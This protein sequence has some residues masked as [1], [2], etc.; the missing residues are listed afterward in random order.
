MVL[1]LAGCSAA[2]P[3][4]TP[5]SDSPDSVPPGAAGDPAAAPLD[6]G[7][8]SGATLDPAVYHQRADAAIETMLLRYWS[9]SAS[10]LTGASPSAGAVSGYWPFAQ[11]FD[12]VIDAVDRT[13]GARFGGWIEGLYLAENARGWS[14]DYYDD[15]N[16]MTLALMRA[17]DRNHSA[18]YLDQAKSLFADIEAGWDTTCC[19]ANPGG[20]WWNKTHTQKATASNA[21]PVIAGVRLAARTGDAAALAFAE[22]VYAYWR[23]NMVD[24][25]TFAVFDHFDPSGTI[26]K[27]RFTYNEGLMIGAAVELYGATKNSSYLDDAHHIAAHMLAA[28]TTTTAYGKVLFDGTNTSCNNDCQQF[29]GIGF[30]YLSEL[31]SIDESHPEYGAVLQAS[32]EAAWHLARAPWGQFATDWAGPAPTATTVVSLDAQSSAAMAL[33]LFA[34]SVGPYPPPAA[35]RYEAEDGV[36]HAIGLEATHAGFAGW[37]YLAGW[38]GDGQWVDFTVHVSSAGRHNVTLRY[39]AG[40]GDATRLV[41]VN[42]AVAVARQSFASTGSWNS[43]ASTTAQVA[44]PAGTSTLSVIYNSSMGSA[45]YL[46]LDW[47]EIAP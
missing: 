21:G 31:Y 7:S 22:K 12:A 17:Y 3:G 35:G 42:G 19:G 24:P 36:L 26:V 47:I 45:S 8:G 44:L 15:E 6:G 46:N 37:G 41:Y 28:E 18:K 32:A 10:Y 16:W 14:R 20:I 5:G 43:W 38:K 13:D 23:A 11:A 40:G 9:Q 2:H 39:A 4:D 29:K 33:N 30:R 1:L 27:Y 25:S 34:T